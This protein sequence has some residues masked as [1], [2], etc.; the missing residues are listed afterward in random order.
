[1]VEQE[2]IRKYCDLIAEGLE[3]TMPEIDNE[4]SMVTNQVTLVDRFWSHN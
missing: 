2:N 4:D 1:M 3:Q